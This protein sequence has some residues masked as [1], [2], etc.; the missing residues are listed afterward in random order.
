MASVVSGSVEVISGSD[1]ALLNERICSL[2][3]DISTVVKPRGLV[4]VHARMTVGVA[5]IVAGISQRICSLIS[6][7]SCGV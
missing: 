1:S 6:D 3:S 7:I 4:P 2:M 5:S